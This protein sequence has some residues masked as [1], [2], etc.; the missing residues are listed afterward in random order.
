[1]WIQHDG[2]PVA[3]ADKGDDI[4][5]DDQG[6]SFILVDTPRMYNLIKNAKYGQRS[7]KLLPADPGLGVYSFTFVS[8]EVARKQ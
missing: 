1:V 8:C 6:R 4:K 2:K 7:L 3:K 5:Y